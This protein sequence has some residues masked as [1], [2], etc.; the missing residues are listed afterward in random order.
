MSNVFIACLFTLSSITIVFLF[1]LSLRRLGTRTSNFAV[2]FI[3]VDLLLVT[4]YVSD[5]YARAISIAIGL[6]VIIFSIT[7]IVRKM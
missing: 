6:F 5:V 3:G 4:P 2:L 7:K 1:L